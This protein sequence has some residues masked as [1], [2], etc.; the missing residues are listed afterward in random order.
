MAMG[1]RSGLEE[2]ERKTAWDAA[3]KV[4]KAIVG[5]DGTHETDGPLAPLVL[6][7][8]R[9]IAGFDRYVKLTEKKMVKLAA[10]TSRCRAG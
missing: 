4:I 9:S 3:R 8:M 10:Q 7:A 6:E 5:G 2:A 1:Y